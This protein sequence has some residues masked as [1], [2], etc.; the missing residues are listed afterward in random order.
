MD[1]LQNSLRLLEEHLSVV[2]SELQQQED[3]HKRTLQRERL[4]PFSFRLQQKIKSSDIWE[5]EKS[6]LMS[7]IDECQLQE[8]ALGTQLQNSTKAMKRVNCCGVL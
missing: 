4:V 7:R 3:E 1:K 6:H 8:Q 5:E 2:Q